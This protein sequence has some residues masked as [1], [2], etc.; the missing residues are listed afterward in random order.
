MKLFLDTQGVGETFLQMILNK[1]LPWY[2][3]LM[4]WGVSIVLFV[5]LYALI[6]LVMLMGG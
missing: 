4:L 1:R 6:F 2:E 3:N 5:L